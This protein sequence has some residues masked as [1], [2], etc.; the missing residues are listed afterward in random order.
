MKIFI[1]TL[2]NSI[3]SKEFY[4]N[5][6]NQKVSSSVSYYFVLI[7]FAAV[8]FTAFMG[9]KLLPTVNSFVRTVGPTIIKT[10]P[11]DLVVEIKN[12]RATHNKEEPVMIP[13]PE[14]MDVPFRY[15]VVVDTKSPFSLDKLR[16]YNAPF[17]LT[18]D[19]LV[20]YENKGQV[21]ITS[22]KDVPNV[23]IDRRQIVSW[24]NTVQ[25]FLGWLIPVMFLGFFIA[26]LVI[27]TS[28]FVR[29]ILASLLVWLFYRFKKNNLPFKRAYQV[30]IHA[31]TAAFVLIGI[32]GMLVPFDFPIPFLFTIITVIIAIVN[33]TPQ[34]QESVQ[35]T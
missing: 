1:Q 4:R 16:E 13:F 9:V 32:V 17:I 14:D 20:S 33:F 31:S 8:I 11:E 30:A 27:Y 24:I 29:I 28:F 26:G 34:P 22:I 6:P 12:G 18:G 21:K 10:Y 23:T 3:Y 25:P 5:L 7:L 35:S 19:S 15:A 2:Q